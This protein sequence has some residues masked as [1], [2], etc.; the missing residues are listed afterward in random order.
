MHHYNHINLITGDLNLTFF[1]AEYW[2]PDK[3]LTS[4]HFF[5]TN[6]DRVDYFNED[7]YIRIFC[8]VYNVLLIFYMSNLTS[9]LLLNSKSFSPW[10]SSFAAAAKIPIFPFT[11]NLILE[12]LNHI[13]SLTEYLLPDK[14]LV[15]IH[16][17]TFKSFNDLDIFIMFHFY[18]TCFNS[19]NI[20]FFALVE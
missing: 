20:F 15:S 8:I 18:N 6:F 3:S 10:S 5:V 19:I 12:V 16:F 17:D 1:L 14:S 7:G 9:A 13:F 11:T 2:S 4:I